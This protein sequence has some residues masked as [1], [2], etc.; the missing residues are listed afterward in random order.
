MGYK[1]E[2]MVYPLYIRRINNN[3]GIIR[4]FRLIFN[5]HPIPIDAQNHQDDL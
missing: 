1:A 3:R 2:S 5:A 4:D